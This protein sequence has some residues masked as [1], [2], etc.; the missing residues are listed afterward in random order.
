MIAAISPAVTSPPDEQPPHPF[1]LPDTGAPAGV[2][3]T[4]IAPLTPDA[5]AWMW[6]NVTLE[7]LLTTSPKHTVGVGAG[8]SK[9][10]AAP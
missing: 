3:V 8:M 1:G 4:V 9:I 6:A 2:S 10:V 7:S 5:P